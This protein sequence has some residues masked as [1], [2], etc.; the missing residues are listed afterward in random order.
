MHNMHNVQELS[1]VLM[2]SL[3]LY[4]EDRS[5]INLNTVVL[6]NILRK[7]NLVLILD[8]HELLLAL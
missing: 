3:N 1:L 2:Q 5:R 4:I 8:V 7:A 6:L